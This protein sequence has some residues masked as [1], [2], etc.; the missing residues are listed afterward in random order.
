MNHDDF[1]RV[2]GGESNDADYVP[3]ACLLR[4]GYG[5]AGFYNHSLN[6]SLHE[7]VVLVNAH[8]IALSDGQGSSR[9]S[10]SNFAEFIEEVVRRSYA[11]SA[12]SGDGGPR[13]NPSEYG[14]VIPLAA[15]PLNE[16]SVVYPVAKIE[17]MAR[18]LGEAKPTTAFRAFLDIENR[19]EILKVLRTKLW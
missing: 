13:V 16:I 7:T 19:S 12:N 6:E 1:V 4:S 8:V 17:E 14:A 15:I 10:I 9:A 2:I 18:R 5:C 11:T 3:V